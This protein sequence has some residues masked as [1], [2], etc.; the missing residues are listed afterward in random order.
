MA[1]RTAR[2][3]EAAGMSDCLLYTEREREEGR[4]GARAREEA[5]VTIENGFY[6]S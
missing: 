4:G 5:G 3:E 1:L 6:V 2:D